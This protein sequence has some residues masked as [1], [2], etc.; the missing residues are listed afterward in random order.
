MML[1]LK[2]KQNTKECQDRNSFLRKEKEK[3]MEHYHSLKRT[4][5]STRAKEEKRLG[6]LTMNTKQCMDTLKDYQKL[7]E[8]ILKTAELCRKLETEK[9]KVLPFYQSDEV[10]DDVPEIPVEKIE[11]MKKARY[12]E[13]QLLDNFY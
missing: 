8:K 10:I 4:M 6:D 13:F 12:N 7:G 9:E 2:M 5:A 11:G 3:I 1:D